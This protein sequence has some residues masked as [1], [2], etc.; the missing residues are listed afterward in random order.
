[1]VAWSEPKL[2]WAKQESII[3]TLPVPNITQK[4]LD[5]LRGY[6]KIAY[7]VYSLVVLLGFSGVLKRSS[8]WFFRSSWDCLVSI[9]LEYRERALLVFE[10][11]LSM[12]LRALMDMCTHWFYVFHSRL[13]TRSL[14]F[15]DWSTQ[16]SFM[17]SIAIFVEWR[18]WTKFLIGISHVKKDAEKIKF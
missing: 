4:V 1:M 7:E 14:I 5:K 11:H 16:N 2:A 3:H 17:F 10:D 12:V 6:C 8:S 9:L 13:D 15:Y 18:R